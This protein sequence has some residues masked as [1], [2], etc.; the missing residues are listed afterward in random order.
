MSDKD[1]F[2]KDEAFDESDGQLSGDEEVEDDVVSYSGIKS[3]GHS[4][5]RRDG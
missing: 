5:R 4:L 1:D 2:E 3:A